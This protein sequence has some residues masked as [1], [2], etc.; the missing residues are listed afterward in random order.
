MFGSKHFGWLGL[1]PEA[2]KEG[3]RK[4]WFHSICWTLANL[5]SGVHSLGCHIP[6]MLREK[7]LRKSTSRCRHR[8]RIVSC[9]KQTRCGRIPDQDP[10]YWSNE[11]FAS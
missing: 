1:E 10:K 8:F 11:F 5:N 2:S 7:D 9:G 3:N 4:P 6:V